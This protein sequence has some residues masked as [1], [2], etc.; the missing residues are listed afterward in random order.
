MKYI[1][2]LLAISLIAVLISLPAVANKKR[3]CFDA[4]NFYTIKQLDHWAKLQKK[5]QIGGIAPYPGIN[6]R[7]G[8]KI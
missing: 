5:K 3:C 2:R 4:P 6:Q 8:P 7:S 1:S